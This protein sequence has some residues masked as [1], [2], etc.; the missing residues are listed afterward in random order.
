MKFSINF[1]ALTLG[2]LSMGTVSTAHAAQYT[3][4]TIKETQLR[5]LNQSNPNQGQYSSFFAVNDVSAQGNFD[6]KTD[7]SKNTAIIDFSGSNKDKAKTKQ[8]TILNLVSKDKEQITFSGLLNQNPVLL[9]VYPKNNT[10]VYSLHSPYGKEN[11]GI[12]V[13]ILYA[14]C[15]SDNQQKT[16]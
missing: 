6:I 15:D 13:N 4:S 3:C 16:K 8:S 10:A 11:E 1:I 14:H 12:N 9:T 5:Y 7:D 2:L